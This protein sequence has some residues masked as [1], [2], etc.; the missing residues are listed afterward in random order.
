MNIPDDCLYLIQHKVRGQPSLDIAARLVIGNEDVW[1]IPT[2]GHR[3]YPLE[4]RPLGESFG[5]AQ[6]AAWDALPDHYPDRPSR[7]WL[8]A[9]WRTIKSA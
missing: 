9:L 1:L 3:A 2:S 5:L 6:G 4:W 7:G 8:N